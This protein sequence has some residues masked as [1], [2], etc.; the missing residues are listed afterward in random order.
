VAYGGPDPARP[1]PASAWDVEIELG[2]AACLGWKGREV[3]VADGADL[4]RRTRLAAEAG[5]VAVLRETTVLGRT[6]ELGGRVRQATSMTVGDEPVLVEETVFSGHHP[7]PGVLGAERVLDSVT[8]VGRRPVDP[9]G[10][11]ELEAPGALARF[12]GTQLHRSPLDTL[13]DRWRD[14]LAERT[15]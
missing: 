6:G 2:A 10:A 1:G 11:M 15:S 8:M 4:H 3:I 13:Y 5:A 7:V 12:L 9:T 14:E